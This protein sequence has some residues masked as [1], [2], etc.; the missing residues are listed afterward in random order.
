MRKFKLTAE[1][2]LR[3]KILSNEKLFLRALSLVDYTALQDIPP[4][5]CKFQFI[6]FEF[7]IKNTRHKHIQGRS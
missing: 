6:C 5:C 3:S 7:D 1:M 4:I 2:K